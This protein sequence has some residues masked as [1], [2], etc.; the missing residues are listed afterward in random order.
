MAETLIEKSKKA[1]LLAEKFYMDEKMPEFMLISG[2]YT[3]EEIFAYEQGCTRIN[4]LLHAPLANMIEEHLQTD[5]KY[6]SGDT[7][8]KDQVIT[9][10]D[11]L[12]QEIKLKKAML[13]LSIF[14][15]ELFDDKLHIKDKLPKEST[16]SAQS[17]LVELLQEPE[18]HIF[19][20]H[21]TSLRTVTKQHASDLIRA[22]MMNDLHANL[23]SFAV[24]DRVFS[25]DPNKDAAPLLPNVFLD[26][27]HTFVTSLRGTVIEKTVISAHQARESSRRKSAK[28]VAGYGGVTA[29]G[30]VGLGV[31][32]AS[33]NAG[34]AALGGASIGAILTAGTAA[35]IALACT[36]FVGLAIGLVAGAAFLYY[37][38]RKRKQQKRLDRYIDQIEEANMK[39][40]M[41]RY[42]IQEAF[43]ADAVNDIEAQVR[44]DYDSALKKGVVPDLPMTLTETDLDNIQAA[45]IN[46]IEIT[47]EEAA[48]ITDGCASKR[49]AGYKI[50]KFKAKLYMEMLADDPPGSKAK[51]DAIVQE[52]TTSYK[53]KKFKDLPKDEV[54]TLIQDKI[55]KLKIAKGIELRT[56]DSPAQTGEIAQSKDKALFPEWACV[57]EK[58]IVGMAL[59]DNTGREMIKN[60]NERLK[61]KAT[62]KIKFD[63]A[64]VGSAFLGQN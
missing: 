28:Y 26:H 36:G 61:L 56:A 44:A 24:W 27:M 25:D 45:I 35:G 41:P 32:L 11:N 20:V 50:G 3:R 38:S 60:P 47:P 1:E 18:K 54:E 55:K 7:L 52:E 5:P 4:Q 31:V 15:T 12:I 58:K 16:D 34:A 46:K 10:P 14:R 40:R 17:L 8:L 2:D 37:R 29:G 19:A 6:S 62:D 30:A 51:I 49:T 63:M 22:A 9:L 23:D 42:H 64:K 48:E 59:R 33:T 13:I 39:T 43:L 21:S 57:L 53:L